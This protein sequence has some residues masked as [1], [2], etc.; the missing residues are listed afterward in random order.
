MLPTR[1]SAEKKRKQTT[2]F[3]QVIEQKR[4]NKAEV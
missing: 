3:S 4:K 2:R 1:G